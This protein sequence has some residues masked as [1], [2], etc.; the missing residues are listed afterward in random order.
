[1]SGRFKLIYSQTSR[2]KIKKLHPLLKP[3]IKSK[4]EQIREESYSGKPLERELSGYFSIR[5]KRFRVIYKILHEEK[6][7]QIHYVGHR[8]DIYEQFGD[9]I[10]QLINSC[11][12]PDSLFDHT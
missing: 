6:L 2:D 3:V 12:G 7:I 11:L 5:S 1:M 10:K 8:K 4:I 9:Q